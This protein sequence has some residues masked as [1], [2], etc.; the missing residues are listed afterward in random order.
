MA[1]SGAVN[2]AK[3]KRRACA[4]DEEEALPILMV[5]YQV[6]TAE[7][8]SF[9]K[10]IFFGFV[11]L[12][13][14]AL[15]LSGPGPAWA[16]D[17]D[18]ASLAALAGDAGFN[19]PPLTTCEGAL[20]KAVAIGA[21]DIANCGHAVN[22]P[23]PKENGGSLQPYDV[24]A[25]L[26]RW[27]VV[28]PRAVKLVDPRGIRLH[29]ARIVHE[30][31]LSFLIV[32]FP[33]D[34]G[35]CRFTD[36]IDMR[37]TQVLALDFESAWVAGIAGD[38]ITVA[39]DMFLR[40]GFRSDGNVNLMGATIGGDLDCTGGTFNNPK[41]Y[42]LSLQRIDVKGEIFLSHGFISNGEV[43]LAGAKIGGDL[44][45]IEGTFTK[46][47]EGSEALSADGIEVKGDV[48]MRDG[49]HAI[50][51][52]RMTGATIGGDLDCGAGIFDNAGGSSLQAGNIRVRLDVFLDDGNTA[53]YAA[54]YFHT[55][56]DVRLAGANI[57][58]RVRVY[59]AEFAGTSSFNAERATIR[60]DLTWHKLKL[61][62]TVSV[63]LNDATVGPLADDAESWPAKP[64]PG[65]PIR[66]FLDG[67]VYSR[68]GS[69]TNVRSR[70]DWLAR[71]R[72]HA[73]TWREWF[74]GEF[75]GKKQKE[76]AVQGDFTPQPYEQLAK[77]LREA[78]DQEGA[79]TV[80]IE[81]EKDRYRFGGLTT[82]G[83][84]KSWFFYVTVGYG[85][86]PWLSLIYSVFFIVIGWLLFRW[87]YNRGAIAPYHP[88]SYEISKSPGGRVPHY[89]PPFSPFWYSLDN[90]LPIV[91]LRQK[92][93]WMP[94]LHS[95]TRVFEHWRFARNRN[96]GEKLK[97]GWWLRIYLWFHILFGW[98]LS[99]VFL[100]AITGIIH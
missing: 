21:D 10:P 85:Y 36:F 24:R 71:Q 11:A 20:L 90:F 48:F 77:V 40:Q 9:S 60:G 26:I 52:V 12:I 7:P 86:K 37:K 66:L 32:P 33:L 100:G 35:Y 16:R 55:T 68:F 79:T 25:S 54:K 67:F 88:L 56:G 91:D 1:R 38:S 97:L 83:K 17:A 8:S 81:M 98:L 5:E 2:C 74:A 46:P 89:D 69:P 51:E 30:L 64:G 93:R 41:D 50:G 42:A 99:T 84:I 13:W 76:P 58:G 43:G 95:E 4:S 23:I 44:N 22:D 29:G 31:D 27:L 62:P 49:F 53:P 39:K 15:V 6:G 87:G 94:D 28:D 3:L 65:Q 61:A 73:S 45:C 18:A 80:L 92:G 78:G 47:T 59:G 82:W 72:P 96:L 57:Q 70:L 14:A 19:S 63:D 34:F 75:H